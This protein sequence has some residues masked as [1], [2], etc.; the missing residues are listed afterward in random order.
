MKNERNRL[1]VIDDEPAVRR[2][3]RLGLEP[4]GFVIEEATTGKEGLEKAI[5]F[6]PDIILLDLGLPDTGGLQVLESLREWSK[7]PVVVLTVRDLDTEKVTLL[8]AGADDYITKPFSL[9]E[10]VARLQVAQRHFLTRLEEKPFFKNGR[11]DIDFAQHAVKLDGK[12]IKLTSTEYNL[13]RVLALGG[14]KVVT[15]QRLLDEVWGKIGDE[16][17]HYLRVYIG[18]LRKK[19]EVEPAHPKL[20]LTEPNVGYRLNVE[21]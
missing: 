6:N 21:P 2:F 18:L 5:S 16:G 4:R 11:L 13:L 10:L 3:L 1:L 12:Q 9:I 20:I 17:A 15:Q 7:V 19:L 8:E 14:G